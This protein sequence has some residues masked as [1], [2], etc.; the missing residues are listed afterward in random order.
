MNVILKHVF[1]QIVYGPYGRIESES[2]H[3]GW[4]DGTVAINH[5][6]AVITN[7]KGNVLFSG[8]VSL[9]NILMDR[10]YIKLDT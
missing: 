6:R 1:W 8:S 10:D 7:K 4:I 5:D 3:E 9:L 2:D